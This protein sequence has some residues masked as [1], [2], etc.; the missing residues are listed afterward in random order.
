MK[1]L[2][3][4]RASSRALSRGS[5]ELLHPDNRRVLAFVPT[6]ETSASW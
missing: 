6:Y 5:L 1:R 4:H 3:Q 2:I